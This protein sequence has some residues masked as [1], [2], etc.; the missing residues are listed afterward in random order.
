MALVNAKC[1]ACGANLEVDG[2]Q[3]AAI[4]K[5]CGAAFIVEKAVNNYNIENNIANA[6]INVQTVYVDS[7]ASIKKYMEIANRAYNAGDYKTAFDTFNQK[8]INDDP[9]NGDAYWGLVLCYMK[10]NPDIPVT[11]Y[12][13]ELFHIQDSRKYLNNYANDAYKKAILYTENEKVKAERIRIATEYSQPL[14]EKLKDEK[15]RRERI[16]SHKGA[17]YIAT[18]VYGDYNAPQVMVLRRYRDN[19]LKNSA[20]GRLFIKTYYKLSPPIAKRLKNA[21]RINGFVRGILDKIVSHLS[22]KEN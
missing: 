12:L 13:Y 20:F 11:E 22:K 16:D 18:A 5:Y 7:N 6:Q 21:R 17:C 1:T 15:E 3:D 4:C 2:T 9:T 10:E 19:A 8:I 14:I